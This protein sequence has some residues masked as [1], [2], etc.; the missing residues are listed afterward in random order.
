MNRAIYNAVSRAANSRHILS[1]S[2]LEFNLSSQPASNKT[3][4]TGFS[5]SVFKTTVSTRG[6]HVSI[7]KNLLN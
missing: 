6:I 4:A 2:R 5:I 7:N 3:C 1:R